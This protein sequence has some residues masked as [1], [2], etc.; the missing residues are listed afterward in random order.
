MT[1][2]VYRF[3]LGDIIWE[4]F[5]MFCGLEVGAAVIA[6]DVLGLAPFFSEA[7]GCSY[8]C[9]SSGAICFVCEL[10]GRGF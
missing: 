1:T 7:L 9:W 6:V 10:L 2:F 5:I 4:A 8:F 3:L